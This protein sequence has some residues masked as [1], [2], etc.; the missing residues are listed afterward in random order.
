[1]WYPPKIGRG[2]VLLCVLLAGG[3]AAV[4]VGDT[5]PPMGEFALA[6][7][8]LPALEGRVVLVDFWA[9]WCAPCRDS[10]PALARLHQAHADRGLVI[11][12][13]SVDHQPAQYDAFIK[14]L[15]PPFVV[16]RDEQRKLAAAVEVRAMP[17][18]YLIGRDGRVRFLHRGFRGRVTEDELNRQV[19]ALLEEKN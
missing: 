2:I 3:R 19:A 12:A 18:S 7:G 10:F 1:M 9:S 13:V 11:V 8:G 14:K 15:R 17:S 5:F 6:G 4:G 16:R